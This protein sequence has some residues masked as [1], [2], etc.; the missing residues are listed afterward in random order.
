VYVIQMSCDL[1]KPNSARLV[2]CQQ[3]DF[4]LV[5]YFSYRPPSELATRVV[6]PLGG[7]LR[8]WRNILFKKRQEQGVC[9]CACDAAARG[10]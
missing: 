8:L 3:R 6:S 9:M 2:L 1:S 4:N 5:H 10:A 7:F